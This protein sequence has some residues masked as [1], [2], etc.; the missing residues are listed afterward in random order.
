M[1]IV[2][3]IFQHYTPYQQYHQY[4]QFYEGI[5]FIWEVLGACLWVYGSTGY[6][7]VLLDECLR[8]R[9]TKF[10]HIVSVFHACVFPRKAC[11][12]EMNWTVRSILPKNLR[13]KTP[14]R[15]RPHGGKKTSYHT[16]VVKDSILSMAER[17]PKKGK[18]ESD[19]AGAW[20]KGFW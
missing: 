2:V 5:P 10:K 12:P 8:N 6:V 4:Q 7:G 11:K 19:G 14:T 16:A 15:P 20:K 9:R 1:S 13:I 3:G 17:S 18:S